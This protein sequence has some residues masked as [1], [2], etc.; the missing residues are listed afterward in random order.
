MTAADDEA[1]TNMSRGL[2]HDGSWTNSGL[3]D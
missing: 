3:E 1:K 2:Y